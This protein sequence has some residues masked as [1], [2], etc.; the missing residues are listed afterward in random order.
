MG[1][2]L[3]NRRLEAL[4]AKVDVAAAKPRDLDCN[5]CDCLGRRH[6]TV[7][8]LAQHDESHVG[9]PPAGQLGAAGY[10]QVFRLPI[11]ADLEG[12]DGM[13]DCQL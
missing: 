8:R 1:L 11:E 5:A 2:S 12:S 13:H 3:A 4:P 7:P 9:K 6:L 10:F